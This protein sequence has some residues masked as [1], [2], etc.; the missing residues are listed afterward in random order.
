MRFLFDECCD[1]ELVSCL[2]SDGHD[3]FYVSESERGALDDEVLLNAFQEKRILVTED[4]DFGELVYRLEKPAY[5]VILLRFEV[6]AKDSKLH[7]LN[8]LVNK[9]WEK[10]AGNFIAVDAEKFRFRSLKQSN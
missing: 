10:L 1:A 9:F 4:K 5:G 8:E 7:R 2:R 6:S 3:V